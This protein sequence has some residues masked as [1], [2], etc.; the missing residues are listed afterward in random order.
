MFVITRRYTRPSED[1]LWY[2]EKIDF[3]VELEEFRSHL[4]STYV[5]TGKLL[6]QET[7]AEN[8]LTICYTGMWDSKES[9]DQYNTDVVLQKY[10]T[11]KD[12][13]NASVGIIAG[14]QEFF[15]K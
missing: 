11:I 10:W 5:S 9:F 4:N 2:N 13:Y 14:P 8:G 1:I 3:I 15:E 12:Q 6:F 7:Q